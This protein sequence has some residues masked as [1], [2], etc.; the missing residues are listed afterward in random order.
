V[1][2]STL[3]D[4]PRL[5]LDEEFLRRVAY[6]VSNPA[7][8]EF[9]LVEYERILRRRGDAI[10]PILNKL[11]A[12]LAYPELRAIIGQ[13]RSSFDFRSVMDT[14]KILLVRIPAGSLGDDTSNLLGALIVARIQL[15]A[16]SRV[17]IPQEAR[18]PFTLFVDEFS[19]FVT[20]SF[21]RILSEARGFKLGLVCANQYFEQLPRDVQLALT[22]NAA[23]FVQTLYSR[24][25]YSLEVA[26]R[27][28]ADGDDS[29]FGVEPPRPLP[30][31]D[32]AR[33]AEVRTRSRLRYGRAVDDEEPLGA[34]A[35]GNGRQPSAAGRW[36]RDVD[37]E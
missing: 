6:G 32:R 33:A 7:V 2:G 29:V 34:R 4:V 35:S 21:E 14:G 30:T 26:S 13:P 8:R 23:T 15:A 28:G 22:H 37:E 5:L 9:L 24:G 20:S 18:R 25:R 17:D 12:W 31:G 3:L 11:G 27:A 36:G 1:A 16:Q 19:R 10:E